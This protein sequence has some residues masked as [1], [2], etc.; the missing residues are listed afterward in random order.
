MRDQEWDSSSS[1]LDSLDLAKL[2]LRLCSLDSVDGE[3]ALGIVDQA[4]V[5]ASLVDRNHIHVASWVCCVR[6]NLS[7]DLDQAL[8]DD[9]LGF[10]AVESILETISDEDDER[11][12]VASFMRAW[13]WL[14]SVGTG[15]LV[16]KPVRWRAQSLL[17]LLSGNADKSVKISR[18]YRAPI[19]VSQSRC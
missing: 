3:A 10:S 4:E 5:L 17:V 7:I 14:G 1:E 15:E 18:G 9:G 6:S 2:V 19:L 8:H 13:G 11:Q 12:A 16:Q